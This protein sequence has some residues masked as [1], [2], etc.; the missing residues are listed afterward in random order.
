MDS[1]SPETRYTPSAAISMSKLTTTMPSSIACWI[2]TSMPSHCGNATMASAPQDLRS[3]SCVV[4]SSALLLV[5]S[6][7]SILPSLWSSSQ[8]CSALYATPATQPCVTAGAR[9]PIFLTSPAASAED[10]EGSEASEESSAAE[11]SCALSDASLEDGEDV[12]PLPHAAKVTQ[13][14]VRARMMLSTFFMTVFLLYPRFPADNL[15]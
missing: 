2:G 11:D 12:S 14:S 1:L 7:Y 4:I 3:S 8:R 5:K 13:R 6:L 9:M 15:K 10:S